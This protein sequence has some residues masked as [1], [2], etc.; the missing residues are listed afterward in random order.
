M[1]NPPKRLVLNKLIR[2]YF[3]GQGR[4][5]Q[6]EEAMALKSELLDCWE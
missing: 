4:A 2:R 3:K 1:G 5:V 6:S